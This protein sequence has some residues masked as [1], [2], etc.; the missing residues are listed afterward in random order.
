MMFDNLEL[1]LGWI[2][3][4]A[5]LAVF[6]IAWGFMLHHLITK[7][8]AP[9]QE[10]HGAIFGLIFFSSVPLAGVGFLIAAPSWITAGW[11]FVCMI[12][13]I[14]RHYQQKKTRQQ[15]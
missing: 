2:I 1:V 9:D 7:L 6:A 3:L 5:F 13:Y 8:R 11:L 10:K 15:S 14:Y 12:A 4:I